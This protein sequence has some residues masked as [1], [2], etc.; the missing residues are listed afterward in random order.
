MNS[1]GKHSMAVTLAVTLAGCAQYQAHTGTEPQGYYETT[2]DEGR[3]RVVY[4]TWRPASERKVCDMALRRATELG[5]SAEQIMKREYQ[6]ET[7][8]LLSALP[9]TIV[10]AS[11]TNSWSPGSATATLDS[12]GFVDERTVRRCILLV[13]RPV[14]RTP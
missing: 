14:S 7:S 12:P 2:D 6:T 10:R 11:G 4:E 5:V 8:A 1:L 13:D 3:T 9:A